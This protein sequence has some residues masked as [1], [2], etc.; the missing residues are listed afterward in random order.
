MYVYMRYAQKVSSHVLWKI[1]R[2]WR[3]REIQE[4]LYIGQWHLSRFQS[5]HLGTSHSS[6][7]VSSTVQNPLQNPLLESPLAALSYFSESYQWS[8][9]SSF[10]TLILVLGKPRSHR[11]PNLGFRGAESPGW[12]NVLPKNSAWNMIHEQ[13]HCHDEAA[14]HQLPIAVAIF[15][16][17]HLSTNKE[18]WGSIPY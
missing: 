5:G 2:F 11:A 12:F 8:E 18:H 6:P 10:L 13:A 7:S 4:T 14:N 15:I 16:V 17:L 3:R 1:E 9:I